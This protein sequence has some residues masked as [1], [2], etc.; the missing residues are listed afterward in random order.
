MRI[1]KQ[2]TR[3]ITINNW[4]RFWDKYFIIKAEDADDEFL[5]NPEIMK[6]MV[7]ELMAKAY[8]AGV[9][10]RHRDVDKK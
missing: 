1:P 7:Q 10:K 9:N 3:L 4:E 2:I 6:G 8:K 5:Y